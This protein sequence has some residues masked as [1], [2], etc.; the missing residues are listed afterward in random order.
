MND[1]DVT[2]TQFQYK[3]E[4]MHEDVQSLAELFQGR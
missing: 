1:S 4:D 2:F 3:P